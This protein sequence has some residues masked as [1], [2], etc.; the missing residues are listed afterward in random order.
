MFFITFDNF[1]D[2]Y[3]DMFY[4]I[5]DYF[6]FLLIPTDY[7][8]NQ[9]N[10]VLIISLFFF[11]LNVYISSVSLKTVI[12][13]IVHKQCVH[14]RLLQSHLTLCNPVD[15][16]LAGSSIHETLQARILEWVSI[17]PALLQPQT[18]YFLIVIIVWHS[19]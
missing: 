3:H 1:Q 8:C 5:Y 6:N 13:T 12:N 19:L 7:F 2:M 15:C 9:E 10:Q 14:A 16:G 4:W 18:V 11:L 17:P